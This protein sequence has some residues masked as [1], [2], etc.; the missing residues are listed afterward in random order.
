MGP[1]FQSLTLEQGSP[2]PR[3]QS[4]PVPVRNRDAPR[5]VSGGRLGEPLST[6]TAAHHHSAARA[7]PP[8]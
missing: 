2:A 7:L 3:P 4:R 1:H 6:F 8:Q 5:E